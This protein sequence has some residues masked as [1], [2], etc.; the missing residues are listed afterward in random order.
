MGRLLA[1]ILV[2]WLSMPAF[3]AGR[4]LRVP[5]QYSTISSAIL[6]AT[7]A[8][9]VLVADGVYT[10]TNNK[11]L[12]WS[13]SLKHITVKSENG[14]A[15]CIID[16]Q[17]GGRGFYLYQNQNASDVIEGFT[18]RNGSVSGVG[19]GIFCYQSSPVIRNNIITGCTATGDTGGGIACEGASPLIT[20][21]TIAG[22]FAH[23]GAGIAC[24]SAS[25]AVISNNTISGNY[26]DRTDVASG[27]GIY[28]SNC[29]A[30]VTGN[31]ITGN[32]GASDGGGIA[33]YGSSAEITDNY[34][35]G[36]VSGNSGGGIIGGGV[37]GTV[38]RNVIISNYAASGGGL[39]YWNA[40]EIPS[41]PLLTNNI[42]AGNRA[43]AGTGGGLTSYDSSPSITG[44]I[45]AGNFSSNC[46][47]GLFLGNSSAPNFFNNLIVGNRADYGGGLYCW[48]SSWPASVNNTIS[49]NRGR[50]LGGGLVCDEASSP[51]LINTILWADVAPSSAEIHLDDANCDPP[52]SYCLVQGGQ[53]GIGGLGGGGSYSGWGAANLT[54]DPLFPPILEGGAWTTAS[55]VNTQAFTTTFTDANASFLP[56]SLTGRLLDPDTSSESRLLYPIVSNTAD[57]VTI[58]GDPSTVSAGKSY[59]ICQYRLGSFSPCIDSGQ[60]A[61]NVP[62]TDYEGNPRYDDPDTADGA[63]AGTPP[64]DR[65]AYERTFGSRGDAN[66]D[67]IID[68]LDVLL[69]LRMAMGEVPPDLVLMDLNLDGFLNIVDILHTLRRS[70]RLE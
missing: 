37:S 29:T 24:F 32:H 23:W 43:N 27:A 15:N 42:I 3:G 17:G 46:G 54:V 2:F 65:G 5:S 36:N 60:G 39:F 12:S 69:C 68:V 55:S 51:T 26:T 44:N 21:N 38:S 45:F 57:T 7:N 16:C 35:A 41:T 56:D 30:T 20:G 53:A 63:A 18:I 59:L 70:L 64:V 6:W 50:I 49:R 14:P 13:G 28:L 61:T 1:F 8:D 52:I 10:G 19:G 31:T 34:I 4:T 9:T 25:A 47:G 22:N 48:N 62:G 67:A 40:W 11:N 33:Y 58:Y 66:K